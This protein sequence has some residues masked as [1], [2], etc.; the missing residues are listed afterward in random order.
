MA[1]A[2]T[3]DGTNITANNDVTVA[4]DLLVQRGILSGDVFGPSEFLGTLFWDNQLTV[5][6][7]APVVVNLELY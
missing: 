3:F 7:P 5:G 2:L 1:D 4:G 6:S